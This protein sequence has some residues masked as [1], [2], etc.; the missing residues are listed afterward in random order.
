MILEDAL[1]QLRKRI[2]VQPIYHRDRLSADL[3]ARLLAL[4]IQLGHI[5]PLLRV[6]L[7]LK[8]LGVIVKIIDL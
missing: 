6:P 7:V 4:H 3:E 8:D 1:A 2:W 5:E